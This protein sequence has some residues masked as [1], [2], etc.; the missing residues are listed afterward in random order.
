MAK[1]LYP[2]V[3]RGKKLVILVCPKRVLAMAI[4]NI[5]TTKRQPARG[6]RC[7]RG[8]GESYLNN[9]YFDTKILTSALGSANIK[10]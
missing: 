2:A 8:D 6:V 1:L 4:K 7:L 10:P 5:R 9:Y 3:T